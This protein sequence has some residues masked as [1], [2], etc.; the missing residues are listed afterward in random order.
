MAVTMADAI[1]R[2]SEP[3]TVPE[4]LA[5]VCAGREAAGPALGKYSIHTYVKR[6]ADLAER[7]RGRGR[8]LGPGGTEDARGMKEPR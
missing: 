6:S 4:R 8:C 7:R 3:V 2:P 5:L 1:R